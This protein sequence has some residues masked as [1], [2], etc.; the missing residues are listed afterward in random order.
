M[1]P[2]KWVV[3]AALLMLSAC[4]PITPKVYPVCNF[5]CPADGTCT[6]DRAV[7][8]SDVDSITSELLDGHVFVRASIVTVTPAYALLMTNEK[9][10]AILREGWIAA[11][12]F[13]PPAP[14]TSASGT[15]LQQCLEG[16]PQWITLK[17][18]DQAKDLAIDPLFRRTCLGSTD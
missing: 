11:A 5:R 6:P 10:D 7:N 16:M 2:V 3:P 14:P 18:V 1:S 12:C 15:R 9:T 4:A 8:A 13:A 17:S